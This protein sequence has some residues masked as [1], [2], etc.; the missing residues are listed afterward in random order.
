MQTESAILI[1]INAI[2][3]RGATVADLT[4][5]FTLPGHSINLKEGGSDLAV[6]ASN[7]EEYISLVIE[8]T[9]RKGVTQQVDE[10]KAGFSSG[11]C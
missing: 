1:A 10:F 8:W 11:E 2:E 5:D 3:L 9:L 4:L 6:D 7:I